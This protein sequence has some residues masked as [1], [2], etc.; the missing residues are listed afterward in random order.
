MVPKLWAMLTVG[1]SSFKIDNLVPILC[2]VLQSG[3]TPP[4]SGQNGRK[5]VMWPLPTKKEK[6]KNI[7][8]SECT[9]LPLLP[10]LQTD[11]TIGAN[12][13]LSRLLT[14]ISVLL[15]LARTLWSISSL[16]L[17]PSFFDHSDPNTFR[18]LHLFS[19]SPLS[20]ALLLSLVRPLIGQ[21]Q[22]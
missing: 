10:F 13:I 16:H 4:F 9:V 6:K 17:S 21:E 7:L 19:S 15:S 1:T 12:Q 20:F 18:L 14:F 8:S 3:T 5:V 2:E 11:I 22:R